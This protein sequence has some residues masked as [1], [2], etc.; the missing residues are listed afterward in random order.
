VEWAIQ[1]SLCWLVLNSIFFFFFFFFFRYAL[2]LTFHIFYVSSNNVEISNAF[3][4][5]FDFSK[6]AVDL[7]K[8]NKEY[9]PARCQA[10]V[11]DVVTEALP[12]FILPNSIDAMVM[13]FVLSAIAPE[14][15]DAVI[16]KLHKVRFIRDSS[17]NLLVAVPN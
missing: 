6:T 1:L 2:L 8:A 4:Y 15:F 14:H 7:L 11:C 13:I 12:D 17:E 16:S 10:F 3:F 5:S 9:D